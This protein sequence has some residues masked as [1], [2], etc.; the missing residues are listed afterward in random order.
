VR[1]E[2]GVD[3]AARARRIIAALIAALAL[4]AT[5]WAQPRIRNVEAAGSFT[6]K[7]AAWGRDAG[8][9]ARVG[10]RVVWLFGDTFTPTGL[11]CATGAWSSPDRPLA[12][13]EE[14][15]AR[16]SPHQLYRFASGEWAFNDAHRKPPRCCAKRSGCAEDSYCHCP[17]KTDCAAR[18][19]IWPGSVFAV[20]NRTA[21]GFYEEVVAGVAPYDFRHLGTGVARLA[22]GR[23]VAVREKDPDGKPLFVFSGAEPNF[24][25]AVAVEESARRVVYAY[26]AVSRGLCVVDV[27]I[28]RVPLERIADRS[29]Y[30]FWD[31]AGW[32][33][34]LES[35]RPIL[36]GVAA[37]LGSVAW[38]SR[39]GSYV[40]AHSDICSS[41]KLLVRSA[42][43]PEGPWSE[44]ATVDLSPLGATSE[45][46]AGMLH[47][48][49]GNGAEMWFSFYRPEKDG[50]GKVRLGK[51][52]FE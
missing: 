35:A 19:A 21:V 40:S 46:Y 51:I 37:G 27:L 28:A 44:P 5:A 7:A 25:R 15:D 42:P 22:R 1:R 45:S 24:F 6:T 20:D 2:E 38:S 47:P 43:R 41:G 49:L 12:L 3:G 18:I 8:F 34:G 9:S 10:D 11:R 14:V 33:E 48:E 23:T 36:S 13:H 31:G 50:H 29:A 52:R 32:A 39:L 17:P 4:S 16:R 30:R 26:A